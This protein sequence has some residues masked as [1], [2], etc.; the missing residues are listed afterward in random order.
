MPRTRGRRVKESRFASAR[1]RLGPRVSRP[2]Q[3]T[4]E[5]GDSSRM[6]KMSGL[7]DSK[8]RYNPTWNPQWFQ[9]ARTFQY[10]S[11]AADFGGGFGVVQD[12]AVGAT[13]TLLSYNSAAYSFAISQVPNVTEFG[14]L[15]DQYK[16]AGVKV[17]FDYISASESV[18]STT[19]STSLQC[20]LLAYEDN[21]DSTAPPTTNAGWSA[22]FESGRA[23]KKVFPN[24]VNR[25]SYMLKPKYL[26][27]DVDTSGTTTGRSLGSGWVDGATGLDVLW[28]GL[29]V[30]VQANPTI[31][32]YVHTFRITA[33]YYLQWRNR[34]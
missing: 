1:N 20:T 10:S 12:L 22:V 28:R 30:I 29:K 14:V 2:L 21:D 11:P 26:T 9:V 4:Q 32:T 31:T 8:P 13:A 33:T 15:F 34:Q 3:P 23:V 5:I 17:D 24:R 25:M 16:I 7:S 18:L 27:A 19:T 6:P